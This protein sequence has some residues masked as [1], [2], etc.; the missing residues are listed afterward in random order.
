MINGLNSIS[1]N[2]PTARL[3]S[4]RYGSLT[5]ALEL[6]TVKS[7]IRHD[8]SIE[9]EEDTLLGIIIN[10]A[11]DWAEN[12]CG[13]P[14]IK[15]GTKSFLDLP[16][17]KGTS[18]LANYFYEPGTDT[19]R[20]QKVFDLV[21]A[22]EINSVNLRLE[23]GT[24]FEIPGEEYTLSPEGQIEFKSAPLGYQESPLAA[25]QSLVIDFDSGLADD[26]GSVPPLMQMALLQL[27]EYWYENRDQVGV[28]PAG[29]GDN[30]VHFKHYEL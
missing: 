25:V 17:R 6:A 13:I 10:A 26:L 20:G 8:E 5:P 23:D 1:S 3:Y 12:Y 15:S 29:T 16:R 18:N 2:N 27:C 24:L 9:D 11:C 22:K 30:F 21:G 7:F 4:E 19:E 28:I 14:I